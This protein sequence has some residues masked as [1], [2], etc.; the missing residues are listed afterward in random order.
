MHYGFPLKTMTLL[1][2]PSDFAKKAFL[3]PVK[4]LLGHYWR[5][6][7]PDFLR[8]KGR[9]RCRAFWDPIHAE[10]SWRWGCSSRPRCVSNAGVCPLWPF[11]CRVLP[12]PA[13]IRLGLYWQ[14]RY[15]SNVGWLFRRI[16]IGHRRSLKQRLEWKLR[17]PGTFRLHHKGLHSNA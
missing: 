10:C 8:C 13:W 12:T 17:W 1:R 9:P 2:F 3:Q 6:K 5:P 16:R 7:V 4:R 11:C 15:R 14:S